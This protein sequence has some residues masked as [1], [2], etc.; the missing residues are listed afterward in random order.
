MAEFKSYMK[1]NKFNAKKQNYNGKNYDSQ[2]EA[3]Y[4]MELDWRKKAGEIKKITPQYKLDLTVNG[5]HIANYFMDFKVE[6]IDGTIE[7]HEVKGFETD[8]WR[9]KWRL[10][11]AIFTEFRFILIK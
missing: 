11:K 5:I 8:L 10:A 3:N 4:A 2:K 1:R 7:M 9:I 6:L